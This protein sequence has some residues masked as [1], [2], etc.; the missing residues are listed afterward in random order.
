MP[1]HSQRQAVDL[2]LDAEHETLEAVAVAF[3]CAPSES[4][5]RFAGARRR[6]VRAH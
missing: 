2:V 3:A 1:E 5:E 4:F 6:I